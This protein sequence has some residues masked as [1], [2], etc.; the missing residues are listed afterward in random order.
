M[1]YQTNNNKTVQKILLPLL[2]ALLAFL[3]YQYNI[4]R[5][6]SDVLFLTHQ[7]N[8]EQL[9]LDGILHS[10]NNHEPLKLG[11]YV[12]PTVNNSQQSLLSHALYQAKNAQGVFQDYKSQFGLQLRLFNFVATKIYWDVDFLQAISSL[13]MSIVVALFFIIIRREFSLIQAI[14]FC[15]VLIFSPWVVIFARNLYW[16]QATWFLP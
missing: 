13:L 15:G 12:R 6:T 2:I 7:L 5:V 8:S 14:I 9:V 1:N 4:F 16:L 11:Y 3:S 10:L